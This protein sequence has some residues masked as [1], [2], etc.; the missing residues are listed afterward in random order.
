MLH[1]ILTIGNVNVNNHYAMLE[2]VAHAGYKGSLKLVDDE[3][4]TLDIGSDEDREA[5]GIADHEIKT[6][7]AEIVMCT[8]C[9]IK[10]KE[11]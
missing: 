7:V 8:S 3:T 9:S 11:A 5:A 1:V 10:S 4:Y 6:M 2:I